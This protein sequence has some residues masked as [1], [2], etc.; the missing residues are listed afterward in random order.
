M[1]KKNL[2]VFMGQPSPPKIQNFHWISPKSHDK[3]S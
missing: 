2:A 1:G 3:Q